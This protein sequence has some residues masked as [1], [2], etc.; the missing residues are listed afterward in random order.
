[1]SRLSYTQKLQVIALVLAVVTIAYASASGPE[2]RY[3]GAPGD[4]GTC[5]SCHDGITSG[6]NSGG[7][8]IQ[9]GGI[10][11]VYQPGQ[12]Y[13]LIVTVQQGGRQRFGF[14]LT[15]LDS[16]N[17][18][19][20][21]LASVS[22]DTQ[23]NPLTG[24]GG[25]QYIQH[26]STG[27]LPNGQGSRTWQVR[28]TAPATDAGT[29]KFYVAGNAA[30]GNGTNQGGDFIYNN[31]FI[32]ESPLSAVTASLTSQPD[33]ET[34]T[35][36]ATYRI[37]WTVTNPSN[38]NNIELRYSTDDGA[39]FPFE[40]F[41]QSFTDPSITSYDWVVPNTP[42]TQ[43]RIRLTGGTNSGVAI[44]TVISGRFTIAG[45]GGDPGPAVF[46]VTAARVSGKKLFVSGNGFQ[47]G[48][49]VEVNGEQQKTSNDDELGRELKCKKAGKKLVRGSTYQIT[50]LNPDGR[51][52]EV[53]PY[54]RPLD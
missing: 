20:G 17:N 3:T 7:G 29:I 51:R 32:T 6:P 9:M 13:T 43:A 28:W 37:T 42:T 41:I 31:N 46:N 14:Q 23:L 22:A 12:Q 48:A 50:V 44:N 33:G 40:N 38:V 36:G 19:A 5:Y 16:N 35:A 26:S 39:T 47:E 8:S 1:M 34:L 10:P 24:A 2:P 21:T 52:T 45:S 25:R 53:F 30:D 54:T 4:I 27:T 15:A 18:R 49:K 11:D